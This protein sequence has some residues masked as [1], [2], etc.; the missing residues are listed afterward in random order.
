MKIDKED[1]GN[2]AESAAFQKQI[3]NI[4][5]IESVHNLE[6]QDSASENQCYVI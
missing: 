3:V 2:L 1:L 4:V 5:R 6:M